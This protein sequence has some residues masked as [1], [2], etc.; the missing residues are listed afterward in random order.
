D[1]AERCSPAAHSRSRRHFKEGVAILLISG[2]FVVLTATIDREMVAALDWR[3]AGFVAAILFVVRPLTIWLSTIGAEL[4]WREKLLIGW[5]APRGIVAAAV[6]GLF[7]N[8]LTHIGVDEGSMLAPLAFAVVFATV[9][10]HGFTIGPLSKALGLMSAVKPGV[11]IVGANAWSLRL[12]ETLKGLDVP[13][14]VAD[15]DWRALRPARLAE[16]PTYYGEILSEASEHNLDLNRFGYMLAVTGNEA[17]NALVS[18]DLAPEL[19][20]AGVYQLRSKAEEGD[21]HALSITVTGRRLLEKPMTLADLQSRH[22]RGWTFQR[23]KLTEEYPLGAF[24]SEKAEDAFL[25][26]IKRK[27]GGLT[28]AQP[29]KTPAKPEPGDTLIS[30]APPKTDGKAKQATQAAS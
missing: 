30:Y 12:A 19:G 28:F 13:V 26:A 9:L 6:S 29:G 14:T 24:L 21:K 18:T 8:E 27:G 3:A 22:Y 2:V 10:F 11:L 20:R 7:A 17:Y 23:T 15:A 5:I 16:I 4:D 1:V 25:V